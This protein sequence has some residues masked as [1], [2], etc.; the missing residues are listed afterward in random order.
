MTNAAPPGPLL[1]SGRAADVYAYGDGLVLR[2]YRTEQ[3]CLH[4]AAVMQHVHGHGYPVP[5]VVEVVG[6]SMVM[7]RVEGPSMLSAFSKQPWRLESYARTLADLLHELHAVPASAWMQPRLGGGDT[8][9]HMDLHPDNVLMTADGPVVIDWTNAGR[10]RPEA[11]L[12]DLW[13]ILAS[14]EIPGSGAVR[15]LVGAGRGVFLRRFLRHFDLEPVRRLLPA[16][17]EHRLRDPN[18][19]AT[20]RERMRRF[21]QR[22]ALPPQ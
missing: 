22:W 10:A 14:A 3:D 15:R 9:V 19:Q 21:A 20:E 5:R 18:M 8:V 17:L 1:A 6:P 4:E 7:E 12:A 11:E 2:R 13:L 16:A